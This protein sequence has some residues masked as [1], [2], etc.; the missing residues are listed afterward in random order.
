MTSG[1]SRYTERTTR[2]YDRYYGRLLGRSGYSIAKGAA[3]PYVREWLRSPLAHT[4]PLP[5]P[6]PGATLPTTMSLAPCWDENEASRVVRGNSLP[7]LLPFV[8]SEQVLRVGS[9]FCSRIA[10]R[11]SESATR[12][13]YSLYRWRAAVPS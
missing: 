6:N 4:T 12:K 13:G 2:F 5:L 9:R 1:N 10:K 8:L 11:A 7:S 3:L